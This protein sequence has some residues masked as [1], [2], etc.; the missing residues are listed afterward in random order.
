MFTNICKCSSSK[1][2]KLYPSEKEHCFPFLERQIDIVK[3]KIILTLSA[4]AKGELDRHMKDGKYKNIPVYNMYH[5]SYF[6][7]NPDKSKIQDKKLFEIRKVL[8]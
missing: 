4:D 6:I 7:Y 2:D 3:P 5:P 8:E 1:D